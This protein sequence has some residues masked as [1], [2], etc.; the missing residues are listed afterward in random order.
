MC[1]RTDY[2]VQFVDEWTAL[3][4]AHCGTSEMLCAF[5]QDKDVIKT[6]LLIQS[7]GIISVVDF[8]AEE[9]DLVVR[10]TGGH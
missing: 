1:L 2:S 9:P 4:T 10:L 6:M 5:T 7:E 8:S 3:P